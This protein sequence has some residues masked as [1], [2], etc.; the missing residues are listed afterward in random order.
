[1]NYISI[2]AKYIRDQVDVDDLYS[3]YEMNAQVGDFF[4]KYVDEKGNNRRA[5]MGRMEFA[6]MFNRQ[7]DL[8]T[9]V[10]VDTVTRRQNV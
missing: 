10:N 3:I 5:L 9:G 8:I 6:K 4:V 7:L 1:M 2:D